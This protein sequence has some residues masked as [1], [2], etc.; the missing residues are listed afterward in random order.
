LLE[1]ANSKCR[2]TQAL[3]GNLKRYKLKHQHP[4]I[5]I[6][7]PGYPKQLQLVSPRLLKRRG[8]STQDGRNVLMHAIA[9]I[10]FNAINLA[11]DAAYRFR[12]Q[13]IQY[14]R[15]WIAIAADEARHFCLIRDY[16]S[17]NGCQY[18]EL[19]A[20]NGL[21]EMAVKTADDIVARMALVPRVLEARGLDV[22]PNMI[23]RLRSIGDQPAVEILEVIYQDEIA[24]VHTGSK[25][26][27]WQCQKAGLEPRKT[28]IEQVDIHLHGKLKGPFNIAARLQAGFDEIELA[29][30]KR[31]DQKL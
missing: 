14:Y 29:S 26:F 12:H 25:W 11:L 24:H 5:E 30:L 13:P 28:F 17:V 9:H 2:A 15:D 1:D 20:H 19:P 27:K 10:E 3:A 23:Q 6:I 7:N 8:I 4:T 22:T 21:W 16:L 31:Q 18:G